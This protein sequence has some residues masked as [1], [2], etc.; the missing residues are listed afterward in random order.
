V[1][2]INTLQVCW[3]LSIFSQVFYVHDIS[4]IDST[5]SGDWFVIILITAPRG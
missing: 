5:S 1:T 4:E 2:S 3:T